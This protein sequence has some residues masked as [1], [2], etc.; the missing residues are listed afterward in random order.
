MKKFKL[1]VVVVCLSASSISAN[2]GLLAMDLLKAGPS[3]AT[4]EYKGKQIIV[5]KY[6]PQGGGSMNGASTNMGLL[7]ACIGSQ[8]IALI[9][10]ANGEILGL[11]CPKS[12]KVKIA[13]SIKRQSMKGIVMVVP[14]EFLKL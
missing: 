9:D 6:Y 1:L 3:T 8:V 10:D 13:D 7:S 12:S 11:N 14:D 2:A 5:R 4:V